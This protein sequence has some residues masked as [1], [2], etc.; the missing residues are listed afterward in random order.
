MVIIV[1]EQSMGPRHFTALCDWMRRV[2]VRDA[3][4]ILVCC[5]LTGGVGGQR[6]LVLSIIFAKYTVNIKQAR[7]KAA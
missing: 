4:D 3:N 1:A 7:R 5:G 2:I 6:L